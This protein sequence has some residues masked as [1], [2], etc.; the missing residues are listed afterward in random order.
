[1][2]YQ[3]PLVPCY[4]LEYVHVYEYQWYVRTYS[5]HLH[6][7]V[8]VYHGH[9]TRVPIGMEY[10]GIVHVY[11]VRTYV[12]RTSIVRLCTYVVT[13]PFGIVPWYVR[14]RVPLVCTVHVYLVRTI[15]DM[16]ALFQSESCDI[17]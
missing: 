5:T 3:V 16:C 4:V 14:T 8:H 2:Q 12:V 7:M 1:M 9:G 17:T 6:T 13:L 15:I 11:V 10:H